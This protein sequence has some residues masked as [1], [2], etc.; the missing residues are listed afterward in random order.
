MLA[1]PKPEQPPLELDTF[2][3]FLH[4]DFIPANGENPNVTVKCD[5]YHSHVLGVFPSSDEKSLIIVQNPD[6][7]EYGNVFACLVKGNY[8]EIFEQFK[9]F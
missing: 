5:Y 7:S 2:G 4:S 1:E 6:G 8:K 3:Y 9:F